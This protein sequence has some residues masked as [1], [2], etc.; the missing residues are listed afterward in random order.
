MAEVLE[1]IGS[2]WLDKVDDESLDPG[3]SDLRLG[4]S[5]WR[6]ADLVGEPDCHGAEPLSLEEPLRPLGLPVR[7]ECLVAA[8]VA[9]FDRRPRFS[10]GREFIDPPQ[11]SDPDP[12]EGR[13]VSRAS[14]LGLPAATHSMGRRTDGERVSWN[15]VQVAP[16][17]LVATASPRQVSSDRSGAGFAAQIRPPAIRSS[18]VA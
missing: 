2:G 10:Y 3:R 8:E 9:L 15:T 13:E 6:H 18:T 12:G 14:S 4:W 11:R 16:M 1:R 17:S 5:R 7:K